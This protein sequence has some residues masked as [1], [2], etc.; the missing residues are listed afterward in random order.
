MSARR[1][2]AASCGR[3]RATI[4]ARRGQPS[5]SPRRA[6]ER[7]PVDLLARTR[8]R[9][10]TR[11]GSRRHR[12]CTRRAAPARPRGR[13]RRR[14][15]RAERRPLGARASPCSC[16]RPRSASWTTRAS[17]PSPRAS[18]RRSAASVAD[19]AVAVEGVRRVRAAAE[20]RA[21]APR[22]RPR[23]QPDG[24]RVERFRHP[25]TSGSGRLAMAAARRRRRRRA[26]AS[27]GAEVVCDA[28]FLLR[29]DLGVAPPRA[30]DRLHTRSERHSSSRPPAPMRRH[31]RRL[32]RLGRARRRPRSA[33]ATREPYLRGVQREDGF[34]GRRTWLANGAP[35]ALSPWTRR[36]SCSKRRR[37]CARRGRMAPT[38]G[39]LSM[40]R[41]PR[42]RP[43]A[44]AAASSS[45]LRAMAIGRPCSARAAS[46]RAPS[47]RARS[48]TRTAT[49]LWPA[50]RRARR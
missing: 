8:R 17:P 33:A 13:R 36:S 32:R 14:R 50:S 30:V 25:S 22:Q 7:R 44:A 49:R 3:P 10:R 28:F 38:E 46:T 4:A 18:T 48:A 9:A 23:Q 12:A 15:R 37:R 6:A 31:P 24:A 20:R 39:A 47:T 35:R 43:R 40:R 34:L 2:V 29:S 41:R 26:P 42:A 16:V 45:S 21:R 1:R 19:A 11:R 5:T 27:R